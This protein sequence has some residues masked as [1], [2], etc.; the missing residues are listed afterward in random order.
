M[1]F[2][3]W[4]S[5]CPIIVSS[6]EFEQNRRKLRS[7]CESTAS[8]C[9][10]NRTAF[11]GQQHFSTMEIVAKKLSEIIDMFALQNES[12]SQV[13]RLTGIL[14]SNNELREHKVF[15]TVIPDK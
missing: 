2:E 5:I 4:D 15:T 8:G 1:Q 6:D 13:I 10:V 7:F 3:S 12:E 9:K 11:Q 14:R